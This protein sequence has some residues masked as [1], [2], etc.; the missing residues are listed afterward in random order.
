MGILCSPLGDCHSWALHVACTCVLDPLLLSCDG[1]K[2]RAGSRENSPFVR[3]F[4][5]PD[6][7]ASSRVCTTKQPP[8]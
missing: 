5:I 8:G 1:V 6:D 7:R 3:G 4:V 2:H